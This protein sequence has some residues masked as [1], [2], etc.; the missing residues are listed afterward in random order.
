MLKYEEFKCHPIYVDKWTE[1]DTKDKIGNDITEDICV[2]K[3]MMEES[4]EEKYLGDIITKDGKNLKNIQA[5]VNKGKGIVKRILEILDG[6]PF[7]KLYFQVAIILRNS[8][9]S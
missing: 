3:V 6:I 7:G 1:I 2:G 5:R 8:L 4:E 9:F